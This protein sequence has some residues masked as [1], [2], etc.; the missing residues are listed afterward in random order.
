MDVKQVI[1][2]EEKGVLLKHLE[3]FEKSARRWDVARYILL[4]AL[5]FMLIVCI[6]DMLPIYHNLTTS[7]D[8][9]EIISQL[10]SEEVP[11]DV[12]ANNW[13][14]GYVNK[15]YASSAAHREMKQLETFS[16]SVSVMAIIGAVI[17]VYLVRNRWNDGTRDLLIAKVL[18]KH[19]D[20]M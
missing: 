8:K 7:L 1:T 18:R 10:Q 20:E 14:V 17:G 4:V 11:A 6:I 5:C 15:A 13:I 3:K 2:V 9:M 12:T 16:A 19:L